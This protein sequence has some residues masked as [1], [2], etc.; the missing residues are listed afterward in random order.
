MDKA[1]EHIHHPPGKPG[2][3]TKCITCH[4]PMTAFARMNRTDHS[5]LPPAPAA[6]LQFGSP[7]ACNSCHKDQDAAWADKQV[8]QWRARDYQAPLLQAGRPH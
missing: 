7:N 4:M 3:P 2:V 6:T 5:M 8:R 1:A